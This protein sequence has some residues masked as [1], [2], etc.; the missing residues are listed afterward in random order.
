VNGLQRV[1][2]AVELLRGRVADE[3][4]LLQEALPALLAGEEAAFLEWA[5]HDLRWSL[6]VAECA[7]EVCAKPREA[8][9][10]VLLAIAREVLEEETE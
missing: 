6:T 8:A 7:A 5:R 9:V 2:A 1:A 4:R 3:R 10:V